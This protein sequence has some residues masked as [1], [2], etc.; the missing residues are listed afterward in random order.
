MIKVQFIHGLESGPLG[1]KVQHMRRAGF[2]VLA[3]DMQMSARRLDRDNS[4]VRNLLRL[5]EPRL[6]TALGA[7]GAGLLW[8]KSSGPTPTTSSV[9]AR[10]MLPWMM[11]AGAGVMV[12]ARYKAWTRQALTKSFERCVEIQAR[13]IEAHDP[14]ILVGSSWGGAVTME[15]VR[16]GIWRGK[17]VILLA[18]A[19]RRVAQRIGWK[20]LD[21]REE[22]LRIIAARQPITLIH[23][24]LDDTV[25][26]EDSV[27]FV[28]GSA[29]A[30]SSVDGGGH[31]LLDYLEQG[32]LDALIRA[33]VK[34]IASK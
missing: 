15:L 32:H 1:A 16:R 27:R 23:D 21:V 17:P 12:G 30:F 14:D 22:E 11:L 13:H 28:E 7:L 34:A 29:I 31:R 26:H 19:Y 2:V 18:P 25:P 20:D 33:Q 6:A 24:P 9:D 10:R 8:S 4:V 3:P 5:P